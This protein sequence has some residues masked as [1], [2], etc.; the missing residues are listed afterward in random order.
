MADLTR[1]PYKKTIN[2]N[3]A[4]EFIKERE[5]YA[6]IGDDLDFAFVEL[7]PGVT[8]CYN[9]R[10]PKP[11]TPKLPTPPA[12][13]TPPP[14]VATVAGGEVGA[15]P[16][17]AADGSIIV[18]E[19]AT[20]E[21]AIVVPEPEVPKGPPPP[22]PPFDYFLDLPA[23]GA[24]VPFVKNY[25]P[26]PEPTAIREEDG[27]PTCNFISS[28]ASHHVGVASDCPVPTTDA[29]AVVQAVAEPVATEVAPAEG[30]PT[31]AAAATTEAA[32]AEATAEAAPAEAAP[33]A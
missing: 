25:V 1:F 12:L 21:A 8:P 4:D 30:A 32:P 5:R 31:E 16:T 9:D 27:Q 28:F 14:E 7:I 15:A 23:E 11:P 33:T 18:A 3:R 17:V 24:E 13:P 2:S 19:G 10:H 20:A 29:P 26:P 6:E 22:P